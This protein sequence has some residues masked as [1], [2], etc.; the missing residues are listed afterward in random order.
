MRIHVLN[1]DSPRTILLLLPV[2]IGLAALSWWMRAPAYCHL[3]N[4][5]NYLHQ[6]I[7]RTGTTTDGMITSLQEHLQAARTTGRVTASS[8]WLI[9]KRL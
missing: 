9:F 4:I 5:E 6:F 8:A 1:K 7:S 3:S 2:V